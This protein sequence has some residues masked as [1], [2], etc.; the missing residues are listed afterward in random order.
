MF[1]Q[2]TL[3]WACCVDNFVEHRCVFFAPSTFKFKTLRRKVETLVCRWKKNSYLI[4]FISRYFW[5]DVND[6]ARP[7][8][9]KTQ[10]TNRQLSLFL[11]QAISLSLSLCRTIS[12][13]L[14]SLSLSLS[15][16]L[17]L[18]C[19]SVSLKR[20]HTPSVSSAHTHSH[21]FFNSN[22][23]FFFLSLRLIL[24][25]SHYHNYLHTHTLSLSLWWACNPTVLTLLLRL[26]TFV[27]WNQKAPLPP[28]SY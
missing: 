12:L 27:H 16:S 11:I 22:T 14:L 4:C 10:L 24:I 21:Y 1:N 13:T 7:T 20:R 9:L 5:T 17:S 23:L 25:F 6:D 18:C 3:F 28:S 26:K 19:T 8:G 15:H 2:L